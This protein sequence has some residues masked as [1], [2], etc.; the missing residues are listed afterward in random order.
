MDAVGWIEADIMLTDVDRTC[1][2]T[3]IV[4]HSYSYDKEML[5]CSGFHDQD[6]WKAPFKE[7]RF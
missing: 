4:L 2:S 6:P 7:L 1:P 3:N 5:K